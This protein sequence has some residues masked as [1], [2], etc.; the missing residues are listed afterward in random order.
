LIGNDWRSGIDHE[1]VTG[2]V[3]REE[4]RPF[5]KRWSEEWITAHDP[6]RDA[7]LD[8]D[9]IRDAWLGFA[10]ATADEIAA[11]QARLGRSLPGRSRNLGQVVQQGFEQ[12]GVVRVGGGQQH[13]KR[14]AATVDGEVELAAVLPRS[15]E[16]AAES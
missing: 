3:D 13:D 16:F 8:E 2:L 10:S 7:P 9:V 11:A 6:G 4:W 5:L 12:G 14:D 1:V 15:V